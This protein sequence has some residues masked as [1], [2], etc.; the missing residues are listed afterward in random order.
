MAFDPAT[1]KPVKAKG[2]DPSTAK[3][4]GP[5]T[6]SDS[7]MDM[8]R[9]S[10]IPSSAANYARNV[11]Q[12]I[13][14]PIDTAKAIGNLAMGVASKAIPG[15]QDSEAYADQMGQ[16][17]TDRYGSV[18]AFKETVL[19]DPIGALADFTGALSAVGALGSKLP[20][21]AG[22]ASRA[23]STAGTAAT[24][25]VALRNTAQAAVKTLTPESAPRKLYESSAKWRP[26]ID[27]KTRHQLT[28]TALKEGIMPTTAGADKIGGLVSRIGD[29][30][31]TYINDATAAGVTIPRSRVYGH[32]KDLR[33]ELGGPR[34]TA[35]RDLKAVNRVAKAFDEYMTKL[36]KTELTPA[37][38]QKFKQD[39]YKQ[40]NFDMSQGRASYAGNEAAKA[41]A[42]A[43]K[44]EIEKLIPDAKALNRR[45]GDLL[46]LKPEV[47]RAAGRIENRNI[48]SIDPALKVSAGGIIGGEAGAAAGAAA[49]FWEL[50]RPK[51]WLAIKLNKWKK[52]GYSQTFIDNELMP[53][54][55][56]QVLFQA[57]RAE[58]ESTPVEK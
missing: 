35:S 51:A 55:T 27:N 37:E 50:P 3:P 14:H 6:P 25:G 13:L 2:F 49:A 57:G 29:Q 41:M 53:A 1:A 39:A 7:L 10:N 15:R 45:Q 18:D 31:D 26:S 16:F 22:K 28:D 8:V 44:E 52:Q 46:E 24:P 43:A 23:A 32:L 40:I 5:A 17:L 34:L 19:T 48:V 4:I 9:G 42:R 20:G 12:P 11:V 38:L 21:M 58:K 47:E 33:K 54:L 30:L 56:E 36:G